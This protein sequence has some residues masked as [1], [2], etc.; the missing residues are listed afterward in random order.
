MGHRGRP[1]PSAH[2]QSIAPQHGEHAMAGELTAAGRARRGREVAEYAQ[3]LVPIDEEEI[4]LTVCSC[5]PMQ[6]VSQI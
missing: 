6:S 4:N 3:E 1:V 5:G 2:R